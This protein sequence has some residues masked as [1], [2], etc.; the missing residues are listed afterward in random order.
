MKLLPAI[1]FLICASLLVGCRPRASEEAEIEKEVQQRLDQ[2]HAAQQ[3]SELHEREAALDERDRVLKEKEQQLAAAGA[4]GSSEAPLPQPSIAASDQQG[5]AAS[6]DATYQEFYDSLSPYGSWINMPGY[7]YAWQPYATVE[8]AGWRPYTLGHWAY[9]DDGWAWVSDEHFG[10]LTYHYGRWMRTHTLGWVWLPGDQWAPAWVSWRY[11]NDYVGWAPLPPEARFDGAAGIQQWADDQYNLGASDYTF[12]PAADFGDVSMAADVVPPDADDGIYGDSN[13]VTNIYYDSGSYAIICYG[14]NY[15]FMRSK[16]R[17]PLP[18]PLRIARTGYRSNGQNSGLVYGSSLQVTAPRI[19]KRSGGVAAAPRTVRA[20]VM[21]ARLV[22]AYAPAQ[23]REG[24]PASVSAPAAVNNFREP[25]TAPESLS[26]GASAP[27]RQ[28]A[29][30]ET[31]NP[32][33]PPAGMRIPS[34]MNPVPVPEAV[35]EQKDRDLHQ[36]DQQQRAAAG[37][38]TRAAET[39]RAEAERAAVEHENAER[40]AAEQAAA[41]R[42]NEE[43]AAAEQAARAEAEAARPARDDVPRQTQPAGSPANGRGQ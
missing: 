2:E 6:P 26:R 24:A 35:Q 23:P 41:E 40:A 31:A 34:Q 36:I 30:G 19:V 33:P 16:S 21:D 13:N 8:N 7:G 39:E 37:D 15:D 22:A 3:E 38:T 29:Y 9:T 17:R 14:P 20:T 5:A 11:G 4:A 18:P 12:V 1:T 28:A 25:P 10:W 42:I 27:A 32:P 43:R